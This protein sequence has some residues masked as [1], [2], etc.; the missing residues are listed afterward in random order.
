LYFWVN[1]AVLEGE[2]NIRLCYYLLAQVLNLKSSLLA[3]LVLILVS[4]PLLPAFN[5]ATGASSSPFFFENF[6]GTTIDTQKWNV[7]QNLNTSGYPGYGGSA[8]VSEGYLYITG[9]GTSIPCVTSAVN[10]FPIAQDFAV[11]F[12]II[13][14]RIGNWGSGMW[15]S[16]GPFVPNQKDLLAN[17]LQV[18][19]DS[20]SGNSIIFLSK[21]VYQNYVPWNPFGYSNT[22]TLNV[23]IQYSKGIYTLYLNDEKLAS[24]QSNL[25][26]DTIGFGHPPA[27]WVP[28]QIPMN[29]TAFKV[30]S[31]KVLPPT[32]V[33][34]ASTPSSTTLGFKVDINGRLTD[35]QNNSVSGANVVL[36]YLVPGVSTY[37]VLTSVI[38]DTDGSYFAT[39]FPPA[40]G[41]YLL[42]AEWIG[43]GTYAG[44]FECKN[45]SVARGTGETLFLAESN[46][47]LSSLA[48]NSTSKEI[49]FSASGPSG[50]TGYV[51]F[52]IS[53]T[54]MG[55]FTEL[56]VYLDGLQIQFNS[57]SE[58]DMLS[59]NFH[60]NHSSHDIL[61]RLPTSA[62]S[63]PESSLTPTTS[64][65][66][67][68]SPS[69]QP[70]NYP[71]PT[72]TPSSL[73]SNSLTQQP[74]L[75]PTQSAQPTTSPKGID[76]NLILGIVLA[77]A[78]A[79][80]LAGLA[81]YSKKYGK[82]KLAENAV[83]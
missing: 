44:T 45:I 38:T 77:A 43:D 26:P 69:D 80:T 54:L 24:G 52:L 13:F 2:L 11:E 70:I 59:L 79:V 37:N 35:K 4:S 72:P 78:V 18:W 74:T 66:P 48:F 8:N 31:I 55:N 3:A 19:A 16:Q 51:R 73:P 33:S 1:H 9:N 47:T 7:Q 5:F 50:T 30:G 82:K 68:P 58:G 49:S 65:T 75:E 40:T 28:E 23:R 61:I 83:L 71:T 60:Y 12:D 57:F 67:S 6:D 15:I 34:L 62:V 81:V 42:K 46:S 36:S 17:I 10:P 29:W 27:F 32:S 64:L 41:N 22:S 63:E 25:R 56:K 76:P 14:T 39:W 21:E 53:K 20:G